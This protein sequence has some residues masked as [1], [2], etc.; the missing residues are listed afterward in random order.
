MPAVLVVTTEGV[1]GYRITSVMGQ[2]VGS[3]ARLSNAF[4]EG[5]RTM[6]GQLNPRRSHDLAQWR[7]DAV[8]A[9]IEQ[10]RIKGANAV[11]GM[12]FDNRLI[13]TAWAEICAYG[14][15]VQVHPHEQQ[16]PPAAPR[17]ESG[18]PTEGQQNATGS[19]P[20]PPAPPDTPALPAAAQAR[21]GKSEAERERGP[22]PEPESETP[23]EAESEQ[24]QLIE[25]PEHALPEEPADGHRGPQRPPRAAAVEPEAAPGDDGP[26]PSERVGPELRRSTDDPDFPDTPTDPSL[27]APD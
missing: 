14:T 20:I 23:P 27:R 19:S 21:A 15:A 24:A 17:P 11:I 8:N 5:I 9:M 2:V 26:E 10:A 4:T 18:S 1:P 12:R 22:V 13:S 6:D 16:P 3:I 25:S 7:I